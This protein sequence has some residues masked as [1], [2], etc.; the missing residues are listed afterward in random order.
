MVV[1]ENETGLPCMSAPVNSVGSVLLGQAK[2]RQWAADQRSIVASV[3]PTTMY[4]AIIADY[5]TDE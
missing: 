5:L 2:H 1:R 4:T 3:G